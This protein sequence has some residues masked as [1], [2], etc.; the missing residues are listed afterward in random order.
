MSESDYQYIQE[1]VY[2]LSRISLGPQKKTLVVSRIIK[3]MRELRCAT[4]GQYCD[5]L[6]RPSGQQELSELI[7]AISTN[8]TY[9]FRESPHF[10]YLTRHI[11]AGADRSVQR[12]F[13]MWSAACSTGEEPYSF[14]MVL[15]EQRLYERGFEW[16]M[17]ATDISHHVVA[18]AEL[19]VFPATALTRVPQRLFRHLKQE[20]SGNYRVVDA[21]RRRIRFLQ[22]N[23][24]APHATIRE[25]FDLIVCRN[26]MI[27]FDGETRTE[28]TQ[29]LVRR[30]RPGGILFVGHSESLSGVDAPLERVQPAIYRRIAS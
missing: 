8:H 25:N 27:Y 14:A 3:R 26:V 2:K 19:G 13:S 4:L 21:I 24:F 15:E 10:D 22:M 23:L 11:L 5:L 17:V 16:E 30:L 28:L 12:P 20:P 9:F 1:L 29:S 18:R 6:R 7:D